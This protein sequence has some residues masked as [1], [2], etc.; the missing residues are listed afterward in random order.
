MVVRTIPIEQTMLAPF[1]RQDMIAFLEVVPFTELP[2]I[3][4]IL[5]YRSHARGN[6]NAVN[7]NAVKAALASLVC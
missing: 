1:V 4:R 2:P 7:F 5:Q 6:F 3:S